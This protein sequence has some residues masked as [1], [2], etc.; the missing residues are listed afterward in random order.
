MR[1]F[2]LAEWQALDTDFKADVPWLRYG[3]AVV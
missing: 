2:A 3:L 1:N